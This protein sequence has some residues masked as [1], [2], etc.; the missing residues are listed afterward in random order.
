MFLIASA[1]FFERAVIESYYDRFISDGASFSELIWLK[2]GSDKQ[3]P[4]KTKN[5]NSQ[6][7]EYLEFV[8][9]SHAAGKYDF[10]IHIDS[11]EENCLNDTHMW[12][13]TKHGIP[14]KVYGTEIMEEVIKE[15]A[16]DLQLPMLH[17]VENAIYQAK[18]N[19][20]QK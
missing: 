5:E 14:Y 7:I 13:Y 15:I 17:T 18:K 16:N 4:K 2:S 3:F 1:S 12:L 20:F 10:I 6:M 11:G 19:V 8:T 9:F